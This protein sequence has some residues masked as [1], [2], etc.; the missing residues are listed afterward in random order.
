MEVCG[1]PDFVA[2]FVEP[3]AAL[4]VE[5][6]MTSD[7]RRGL[8]SALPRLGLY[9]QGVYELFGLPVSLAL[10]TPEGLLPIKVECDLSKPL[11]EVE[12]LTDIEGLMSKSKDV[13][14]WACASCGFRHMCPKAKA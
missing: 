7:A 13:P 8:R 2:L 6:Q 12:K 9:A 10:Y 5:V 3:P 11:K 14:E 4:L 1:R